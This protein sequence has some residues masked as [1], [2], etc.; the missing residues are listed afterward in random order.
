MWRIFDN[1]FDLDSALLEIQTEYDVEIEEI[2]G[3]FDGNFSYDGDLEDLIEYHPWL[4]DA[5]LSIFN[6][7]L[8]PGVNNGGNHDMFYVECEDYSIYFIGA[9]DRNKYAEYGAFEGHT[10]LHYYDENDS[11]NVCEKW[12]REANVLLAKSSDH[13]KVVPFQSLSDLYYFLDTGDYRIYG[14]TI[15]GDNLIFD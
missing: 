14:D 12:I 2:R 9:A 1:P 10:F 7:K 8:L 3:N 6:E 15:E 11:N 13:N 4:F 5:K